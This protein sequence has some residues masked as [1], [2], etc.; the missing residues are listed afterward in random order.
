MVG[1]LPIL[2]RGRQQGRPLSFWS[3]SLAILAAILRASSFLSNLAAERVLVID[4]RKRLSATV[5][6]NIRGVLLLNGPGRRGAAFC[7]SDVIVWHRAAH[8]IRNLTPSSPRNSMPCSSKTRRIVLR[9]RNC[10]GGVP[11]NRSPRAIAE[12]ETPHRADNSRTD[13]F[14]NARAARSCAPLIAGVVAFHCAN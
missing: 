13:H 14:S 7:R 11:L 1:N 8:L 4:I 12:R 5:A 10:I 2:W 6:D 3:G 9:F